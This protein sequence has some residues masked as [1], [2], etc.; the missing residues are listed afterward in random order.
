ML[1]AEVLKVL[2]KE[3]YY[4]KIQ[5]HL[6]SNKS[7]VYKR[8]NNDKVFNELCEEIKDYFDNMTTEEMNKYDNHKDVLNRQSN[9]MI[10]KTG[11]KKYYYN[12]I[13]QYIKNN[14][15]TKMQYPFYYKNLTDA[16]Y[17]EIWGYPKISF[18]IEEEGNNA[19]DLIIDRNNIILKKDGRTFRQKQTI[20]DDEIDRI[21]QKLLL[22]NKELQDHKGS[23]KEVYT[24]NNIRVTIY[25]RQGQE[26]KT[27][28]VFRKYVVKDYSFNKLTQLSTIPEEAVKLIQLIIKLK[29]NVMFTGE[30][31]S[32]KTTMLNTF[33]KTKDLL[34]K[35]DSVCFMV[36]DDP[37]I[38]YQMF[39]NTT[40][41]PILLNWEKNKNI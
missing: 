6:N 22:I 13:E 1:E 27:R 7:E 23:Y 19:T 3:S 4:S 32:G 28:M 24:N 36:Q 21:E 16:V 10:G 30:M 41:I 29:F 34:V 37:E 18:W 11:E 14:N 33:L 26:R 9:A 39:K 35:D 15:K 31:A 38:E 17:H 2:K 5:K 40:I 8:L 12:L 25:N 20:S